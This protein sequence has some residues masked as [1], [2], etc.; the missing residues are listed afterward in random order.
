M[1]KSLRTAAGYSQGT[2]RTDTHNSAL[3]A[4]VEQLRGHLYHYLANT[5][6]VVTCVDCDVRLLPG[7][8]AESPPAPSTLHALEG[9]V[10][11]VLEHPD[12][13]LARYRFE[14]AA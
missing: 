10:E 7:K 12:G 2:M 9:Q 13:R 8:L 5:D 3:A 4:Q 6:G 1:D 11:I 14:E